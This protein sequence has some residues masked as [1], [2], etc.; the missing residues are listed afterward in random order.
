MI[1][2]MPP[3]DE[4]IPPYQAEAIRPE[5]AALLLADPILALRAVRSAC[6]LVDAHVRR[7]S[8]V[9]AGGPRRGR[10]T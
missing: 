3:T 4:L 1:G 6:Q 8:L 5:A 2:P 9:S 7:R 10:H